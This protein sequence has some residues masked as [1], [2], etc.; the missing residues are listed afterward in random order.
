[1]MSHGPRTIGRIHGVF[2]VLALKNT[3]ESIHLLEKP[4]INQD[5]ETFGDGWLYQLDVGRKS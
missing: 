1:M 2:H 3:L 5:L 4:K